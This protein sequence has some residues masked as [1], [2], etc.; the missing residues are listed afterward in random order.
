MKTRFG[1]FE[2]A[3]TMDAVLDIAKV[4]DVL[5]LVASAEHGVDEFGKL[6]VSCIKA[7]GTPAIVGAIAARPTTT[8]P[9]K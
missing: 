5:L 7:Q 3:R 9:Q 6:L 2:P 4:A 8:Q 1:I